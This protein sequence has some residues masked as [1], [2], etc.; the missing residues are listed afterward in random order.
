MSYLLVAAY[1]KDME[2]V[3]SCSLLVLNLSGKYIPSLVLEPTS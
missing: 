2:E 3:S 1:I